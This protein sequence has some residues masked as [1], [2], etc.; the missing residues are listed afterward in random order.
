MRTFKIVY[1][2]NSTNLQKRALEKLSK[3]LHD[4]IGV[5]P[6][7]EK[8][9]ENTAIEDNCINIYLGTKLNN[10]YIAQNSKSTLTSP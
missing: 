3:T 9:S 4:A 7:C 8:Y 5:Y 2:D 6:P 10:N 1:G